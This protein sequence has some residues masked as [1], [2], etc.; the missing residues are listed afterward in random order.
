MTL[1]QA[2]RQVAS[3]RCLMWEALVTAATPYHCVRA[4]LRMNNV[5]VVG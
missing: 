3:A 2:D 4:S 5:E 1:E